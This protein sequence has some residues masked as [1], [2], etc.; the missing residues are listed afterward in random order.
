MFDL[1]EKYFRKFL[2]ETG[3]KKLREAKLSNSRERMTYSDID[4]EVFWVGDIAVVYFEKNSPTKKEV[5]VEV[6]F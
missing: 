4:Y 3:K 1:D 5:R 2:L 6:R